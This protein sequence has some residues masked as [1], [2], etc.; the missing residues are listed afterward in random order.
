MNKSNIIDKIEKVMPYL[1][2]TAASFFIGLS[3]AISKYR[4]AKEGSKILLDGL[5]EISD[6]I[7]DGRQWSLVNDSLFKSHIEC[8]E[9][10]K[11]DS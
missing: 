5:N 10:E 2:A 3:M 9:P 11:K 4:G 7:G 1:T 6:A 8:I